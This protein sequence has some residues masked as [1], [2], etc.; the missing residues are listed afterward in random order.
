MPE[1]RPVTLL[2]LAIA[3]SAAVVPVLL[4]VLLIVAELRPLDPSVGA[5]RNGDRH[6]SIRQVAALKTFERAIVR[7]DQVRSALPTA[8]A[9][10]DGVPQCRAEWDGRGNMLQQIRQRLARAQT[11]QLSPAERL[12]AQ[13]EELD[14]ALVRFSTGANRRVTDAVGLDAARWFIALQATLQTAVETPDYPG[15]RFSVQCA[16]IASAVAMLSRGDG[17]MLA[18]LA[19]RG[20]VVERTLATWRPEQYVDISARQ[21]ARRNPWSGL[22]GCVYIGNSAPHRDVALPAYFVTGTRRADAELCS[23]PA[24]YGFIGDDPQAKAPEPIVG[25]ANDAIPV[26]DARWSVPP[27]LGA[28]LQPLATLQRPTGALYRMYTDAQPM[29]SAGYRF[30]PNRIDVHGSAVDVAFRWTSRSIPPC[31]RSRSESPPATRGARTFASPF[32]CSARKTRRSRSVIECSNTPSSGWPRLRSSMS[33]RAVSRRWPA[34]CRPARGR[35]TTVRAAMRIA[36]SAFR[37]RSAI[38]PMRC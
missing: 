23:R 3:A 35:S 14:D 2:E 17:R 33:R 30:G 12:A 28:M 8:D 34:R 21:I 7:R 24:M 4:I 38:V 13:V 37:I 19:W 15:R 27:S 36:T 9:L 1:R 20:T 22:P 10:L 32:D 31:R 5:Q 18:A 11:A 16:D 26:D 25:E 6:V 29:T